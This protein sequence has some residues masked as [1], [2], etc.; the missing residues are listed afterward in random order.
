MYCF[1]Q[2]ENNTWETNKIVTQYSMNNLDIADVDGDNDIDILT[3]EHK[4]N[5][6]SLQLWIND[7]EA[8]F[9]KQEIDFG[10]ENHLGTKFCDLDNDGDL[11]IVGNGWDQYEK[12]NIWRNDAKI[13]EQDSVSIIKKEKDIIVYKTTFEGKEHFVIV[14]PIATYYYDKKGG[15]FSRMIDNYG[16]DWISFKHEPW[17]KF[18]ESA[19]SSFRGLPNLVYLGKNDGAGHPGFEQCFSSVEGNIITT[20]TKDSTWLWTWTFTEKYAELSIIK[21]E[22]EYW[23]LYEGTPGGT[24]KPKIT[25][26]GSNNGGPDTTIYDLRG[27]YEANEYQWMYAGRKDSDIVFYMQLIDSSLQIAESVKAFLGSSEKDAALDKDGMTVFGFGRNEKHKPLLKGN[28]T[29]RIGFINTQGNFSIIHDEI[30][31]HI[32][33]NK[34]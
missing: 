4:G 3:C 26:S 21:S 15:G 19:S 12:M 28:N 22:G 5:R 27:K 11:D 31:K 14:S 10:K 17:N 16:N 29:F 24:Y 33:K 20:I 2:K 1:L 13:K 9:T 34:K 25:F 6:L 7:G 23:F 18:P 8:I 32:E 30:A